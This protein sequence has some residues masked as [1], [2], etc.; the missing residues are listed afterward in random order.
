MDAKPFTLRDVALG[1]ATAVATSGLPSKPTE[2]PPGVQLAP[3]ITQR[4][5]IVMSDDAWETMLEN[6]DELAAYVHDKDAG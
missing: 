1:A 5:H 4:G 2:L 3:G 6:W